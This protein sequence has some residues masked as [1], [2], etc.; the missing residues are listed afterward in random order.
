MISSSAL[1]KLEFSK[2]LLQISR[3]TSTEKGKALI[4]SIFPQ[5]SPENIKKEAILVD[6][7]RSILIESEHPP[8]EYLPDLDDIFAI[9]RIEG[10]V[11]DS[12]KMLDILKLLTVSRRIIQYLKTNSDYAPNLE[13]L[14]DSFF[15][16]KILEHHI[17]GIIDDHGEVKDSA[18]KNLGY[19]RKEIIQK[20]NELEKSVRS[21]IKN[22]TDK[23]IVREEYLTMRDG[24]IVIP[25]KSEHK[26]HIRGFI[27]SESST[28]Q[29][30]YIEPE[31][32]LDLN[33]DILSLSFAEKREIERLLKELTKK[34]GTVASELKSTLLNIAALDSIFARASYSIEVIG[35]F[36]DFN[37][38]KPFE[39]RDGRHPLLL[40][41][42]AKEN[43]I[44]LNISISDTKNIIIITGPNAGGKTVVL[45]TVGLLVVMV[46]SGIPIPASPDSNFRI[47]DNVLLDIGDEQSIDDDL[48]TFSSHLA[49]IREI[50]NVSTPDTLAL[51]DEIGTGTDPA[52]GAA[53]ASAV[54]IELGKKGTKV[55]A[56]T[57]HGSLKLIA[58]EED[59][60]EN[61]AMEFD[62]TNLK[63]TYYF[64]QGIPGSSY[65]FEIA[66]RIGFADQFLD[67]AQK[68]LDSDKH[69]I[70]TFLSEI[71]AK[72]FELRDKLK[73]MEIE[74]TRL[75]GLSNLY[76]QN[77]DKLNNEKKEILKKASSDASD[78]LGEV[79]K[80][81]E[82]VIKELKET[83]ANSASIKSAKNLI[84]EL[85][86]QNRELV[87]ETVDLREEKSYF[88]VGDYVTIKDTQ[89]T[90]RLLEIDEEKNKATLLA[91]N[92]K[93]QVKLDSLVAGKKS[94]D[95]G[96]SNYSGSY[97]GV[98]ANIRLD[99]RGQRA[100]EAEYEIIKFV[101]DAYSSGLERIE[102]LHGK[103]TGA[104]RKLVHEILK[105]HSKVLNYFF[106]PIELGGEGITI[107]ELSRD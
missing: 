68:Y 88:V 64:K 9:S 71:E 93:M 22:L 15:V 53:L 13:K 32:T 66:K 48:S 94:S 17:S 107:A 2:I 23:E 5:N 26:R 77:L 62:H 58:N 96:S 49:N 52:E 102:I 83:Q 27:H 89:T 40:K 55:L 30:V 76:K 46:Q 99:L 45:K 42:L 51:V 6:E 57:H 44:P 101:D 106:A 92:I 34:I 43:T 98:Q 25:V 105:N 73:K 67:T 79:N 14:S 100:I 37:N 50:L 7:A 21:I 19:I 8:I 75:T 95:S 74:N 65:A 18:S 24:R 20:K 97:S 31:E 69:N 11:I 82:R 41:R 29:T 56:T 104:L 90:G 87:S 59:G 36:P 4:L 86:E 33:N 61:A 10:Q 81:V 72:S 28:G 91:G 80:K 3:Y 85:M 63:P 78:Y 16:N 70:E 35:S 38:E 84:S 60:F 47:F 1:E 39:I 54:L 12:K 103:G